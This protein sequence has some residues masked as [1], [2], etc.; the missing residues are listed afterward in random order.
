MNDKI[1]PILA[2]GYMANPYQISIKGLTE[3][4]KKLL[5]CLKENCALRN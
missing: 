2:Q 3:A 1:C 4:I 5:K